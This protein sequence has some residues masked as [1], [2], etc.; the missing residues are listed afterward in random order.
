MSDNIPREL[1][2]LLERLGLAERGEL[3]A[4]EGRMRRLGRELPQFQSIWVDALLHARLLTPYQAAEINAGR[5]TDLRI[6]PYVLTA[7]ASSLGYARR[8]A[9]RSAESDDRVEL[10]VIE[11]LPVAAAAER[12]GA[13]AARALD[14]V[15]DGLAPVL[16]CG[17]E[18]QRI[19]AMVRP[20]PGRT[21]AEHIVRH[22]R[23]PP[24][25]VLEIARQMAAALEHL[26]RAG[27]A[28]GDVSA[29][30][31]VL[32]ERGQAA[33]LA[34][35]L[36]PI[37][38]PAEGFANSDLAP[39]YC[40]GLAPER[41]DGGVAADALTDLYGCGCL[42][43]HLLTGRSCFAGGDALGKLQAHL[44]HEP[45]DVRN[46]A[47][48]APAELAAAIASCVARDPARRPKSAGELRKQLGQFRPVGR[49]EVA[50]WVRPS[51][52]SPPIHVPSARPMGTKRA[53]WPMMA[54][55]A[56]LVGFVGVLWAIGL[57]SRSDHGRSPAVSQATPD[58]ETEQPKPESVAGESN[59]TP[60]PPAETHSSAERNRLVLS[61]DEPVTLDPSTLA[62]GMH[63][64]GSPGDR[65]TVLVR[66][67]PLTV[68]NEDLLFDA[69][70][71][72]YQ[73]ESG[74][75]SHS[76]LPAMLQV[77]SGRIRFRRCTFQTAAG[78]SRAC[79]AVRWVF[80]VD[81]GG[82]TLPTGRL[83]L[84][85]CVFSRID[86]AV[87]AQTAAALT[88][89]CNNL[90]H[91][92]PG[93]LVRLDHSPRVDE[94]LGLTLKNVTL[95][96]AEA[97]LQIH[98][99]GVVEKPGTISVSAQL[100]VFAPR[101]SGALLAF[102]GQ[103]APEATAKAIYW[104]GEGA[105]VTPEAKIAQWTDASGTAT[106]LND[107]AFSIAGLVRSPVE[108]AGPAEPVVESNSARRW[109]AP[110][111]TADA[112]GIQADSLPPILMPPL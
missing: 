87:D 10:I 31:L 28:H 63:V 15:T 80:P 108:F 100:C 97:V 110:L 24:G 53:A 32:N 75:P 99:R 86:A 58:A 19:W 50:R 43:W 107:E 21:A 5:G 3:R 7:K 109:Q 37:V 12:L 70:D 20:D 17:A 61:A 39:E 38:R 102:A 41:I 34:P 112:P 11:G 26:E 91:L 4:V 67:S 42:W 101:A 49:A 40:D 22:G 96:Q 78:Q 74:S 81:R 85:D 1:T 52:G 92:G 16:E 76:E 71:F 36:R 90:L 57:P 30:A 55:G 47:P 69:I 64:T 95:R 51:A 89:E 105:L 60:P 103:T 44:T 93:P 33:L 62:D 29:T 79:T 23:M 56:A 77:E 27:M 59:Q 8:F 35:G 9:A 13:L 14:L 66:G 111:P 45:I 88:I 68:T 65:T 82:L 83:S 25:V 84:D 94:P 106:K 98:D 18:S 48:D 2:E 73:T 46:L 104:T 72:I 54:T 6:G